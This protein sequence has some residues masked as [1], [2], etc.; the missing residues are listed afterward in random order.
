MVTSSESL[1]RH[2]SP[3]DPLHPDNKEE[4]SE[5]LTQVRPHLADHDRRGS[6]LSY[7]GSDT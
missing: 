3:S 6:P 7:Q 4:E 2:G 5:T 1:E